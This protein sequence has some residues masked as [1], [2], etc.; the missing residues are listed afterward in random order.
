MAAIVIDASVTLAWL[1]EEGPTAA[2]VKPVLDEYELVAPWLWR[3]EVT[4]AVL[5]RQR[6]KALTEFQAAGLLRLLDE[7]PIEFEPEPAT[8][9]ATTLAQTARPHQL[10]AYDAIYFDLANRLALPLF[11]RDDNLRA[12]ARRAGVPLVGE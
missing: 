11:T 5:V 4:N 1:F 10:S 3:L 8:R 2:Q 9:T 6:R 12:A 7:L